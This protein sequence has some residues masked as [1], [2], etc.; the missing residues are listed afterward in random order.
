[1][2]ID[3]MVVTVPLLAWLPVGQTGS[4]DTT[5]SHDRPDH[6]VQSALEQLGRL[7]YVLPVGKQASVDVDAN[8]VAA[9]LA[10]QRRHALSAQRRNRRLQ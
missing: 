2:L 8:K 9:A 7:G 1:M 10:M 3:M 6:V 4:T 5:P